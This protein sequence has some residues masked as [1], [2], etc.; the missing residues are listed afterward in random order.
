[1][2]DLTHHNRRHW[3][4]T[5]AAGAAAASVQP[6]SADTIAPSPRP[7]A[8]IVTAYERGLHADVLVGK[9]LEGWEQKGGPRPLLKLASLY[10]DQFTDRDMARDMAKKHDVP[11]FDT[12]E[13]AVTVGSTSIPVDGVISI[14]E[15]GTYPRN[16]K[17]QVLHPR[18]RFFEEITDAFEKHGSVVPVFNDKHL[19][20]VWKDAKWMYDRAREL[21]VPFMAGT[22]M[23]VGYRTPQIEVP[24]GCEIEA[25]V[26]VGYSGLDIY[27]S[28]AL[29]FFQ[30]H[31]E[32]RRNAEHGVSRVRCL[33]GAA[34]WKAIDR[35]L[36]SQDVFDAA[37]AAVPHADGDVRKQTNVTLFLFHYTDG[38]T[39]AVVMLPGYSRGTS[40]ALKLKDSDRVIA[41][42]FDERTE[43]RY[44][45]FAWLL[46]GIER[47]VHTGTP[48]YPVERTLLSSGILDRALTSRVEGYRELQTPELEINY[49]AVDYP[50]APEPR[51]TSVPPTKM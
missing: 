48:A 6:L 37:L 16:K 30:W 36:V 47:M 22:S 8:A 43:P 41:T 23:T 24:I 28:H 29:D 1:M 33:E 10:V 26:G 17:G 46:K 21:N 19:G 3:I 2:T 45:H 27:G 4:R 14:G 40:I 5:V 34:V 42:R 13:G 31:A 32:R 39:G 38:L 35:G 12:I 50:W 18:R 11:I 51:L 15:H 49:T 44:P 25:A 20:P 7:V 9:I